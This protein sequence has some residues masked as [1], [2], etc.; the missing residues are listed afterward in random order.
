MDFPLE[1]HLPEPHVSG[2]RICF[3]SYPS[4]SSKSISNVW[5]TCRALYEREYF[6]YTL[7]SK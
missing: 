5:Q 7:T 3:F 4:S 1:F 6:Y 2:S